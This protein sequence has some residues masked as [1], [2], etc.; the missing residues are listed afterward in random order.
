[1]MDELYDLQQD[2]GEARNL[3]RGR[4]R[5]VWKPTAEQLQQR[6]LQWQLS[7]DDP[8]PGGGN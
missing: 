4:Q 2:P 1:M 8:I 3:L 5:E 7:I 6:L